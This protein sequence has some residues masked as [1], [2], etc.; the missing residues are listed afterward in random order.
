[1]PL[2]SACTD[3]SVLHGVGRLTQPTR[4][5]SALLL[6]HLLASPSATNQV[7]STL[8]GAIGKDSAAA[9]AWAVERLNNE[10]RNPQ[11]K[12][13]AELL[14][15]AS[16]AFWRA[17]GVAGCTV[18]QSKHLLLLLPHGKAHSSL[19]KDS[20]SP[21]SYIPPPHNS[22]TPQAVGRIQGLVSLG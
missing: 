12:L 4:T 20:F 1:M 13:R 11:S 5:F 21:P 3:C 14:P 17:S 8:G 10:V 18:S 6:R 16:D 15:Q 2:A 22:T 7:V 9:A 19:I